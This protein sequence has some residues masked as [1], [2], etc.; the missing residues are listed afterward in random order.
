MC[1]LRSLTGSTPLHAAASNGAHDL[2][3][4]FFR[5]EEEEDE[6]NYDKNEEGKEKEIEV[7]DF[8]TEDEE[9]NTCI[10][11]ALSSGYKDLASRL[12]FYSYIQNRT[13]NMISTFEN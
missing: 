9:G 4:L 13:K 10:D 12:A 2:I 8:D 5:K 11:E 3:E 7:I 6:S 1:S